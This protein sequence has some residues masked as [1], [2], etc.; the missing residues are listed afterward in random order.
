[1]S[2][3]WTQQRTKASF[4]DSGLFTLKTSILDFSNS[5]STS[6]PAKAR[7]MKKQLVIQLLL[8]QHAK[9]NKKKMNIP[10]NREC[11]P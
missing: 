1:M 7:R 6:S 2:A 5:A 10:T 4:S 8:K 11:R 9:Q 3:H